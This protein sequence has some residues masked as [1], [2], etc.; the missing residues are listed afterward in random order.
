MPDR[1]PGRCEGC[2]FALD[3]FGAGANSLATLKNLQIARVKIDGSFV[4]DL[5][6]N[7][8]SLAAVRA[9]VELASGLSMDTVAEYVE[10]DAIAGRCAG[11]ASTTLRATHTANR[12]RCR[13][14]WSLSKDESQRLHRLFLEM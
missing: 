12:N 13:R 7:R 5:S 2:R 6:T 1:K 11:S 14:Y 9:I 8:N 4:R 3:G 10:N